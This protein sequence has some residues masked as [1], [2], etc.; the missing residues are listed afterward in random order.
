MTRRAFR[1]CRSAPLSRTRSL[2]FLLVSVA[3]VASAQDADSSLRIPV[4]IADG[5]FN[6]CDGTETPA[7]VACVRRIFEAEDAE[8]NRVYADAID[9]IEADAEW[10]REAHE[11][12][13]REAQRLWAA[14]KEQDCGE[15]VAEY[16]RWGARWAATMGDVCRIVKTRVRT[17][18]LRLRYLTTP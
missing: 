12:S 1:G 9:S 6:E 13:L 4:V 15:T 2:L 5:G 7:F 8:L 18:E 17:A 10:R 14:F 3:S 16:E 11:E